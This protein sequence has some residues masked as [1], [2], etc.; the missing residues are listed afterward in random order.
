[1][2]TDKG[3]ATRTAT[4]Q[5]RR[6]RARTGSG[7]YERREWT[8]AEDQ[9]VLAHAIPDRELAPKLERSVQ[10]IQVRRSRLRKVA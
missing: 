4:L 10:A 6:Y 2:Y 9:A 1:L 5:K 8:G 3:K 7:I